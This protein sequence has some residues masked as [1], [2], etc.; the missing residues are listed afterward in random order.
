MTFAS[1]F[2]FLTSLFSDVVPDWTLS[3]KSEPL[4][5]D[6]IFWII[7]TLVDYNDF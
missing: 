7:G 4:S 1:T 2:S 6:S 3:T 5:Y